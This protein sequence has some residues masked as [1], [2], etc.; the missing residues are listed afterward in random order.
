GNKGLYRAE[1]EHDSCGVGFVAHIKGEKSHREVQ[2]AL[3]MLENMEHRGACGCD[4]DSGDGAGIMV[5]LPHRFFSESCADLGIQL[6]EDGYYGTGMAF[7][8]KDER[9][10]TAI[11]ALIEEAVKARGMGF[12]GYR[13]VPVNPE[14]VGVTSLS[15]EPT[16][17]QFFVSRPEGM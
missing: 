15:V 14:G 8:P 6:G 7:L 12:L 17:I 3:M 10:A 1:F 4:P 11:R 13:E 5:Q 2:D 16:V 9:L